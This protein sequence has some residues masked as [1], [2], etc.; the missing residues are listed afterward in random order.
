MEFLHTLWL[1]FYYGRE[2]ARRSRQN[3]NESTRLS[4]LNW[5]IIC[6]LDEFA[7][8]F[9]VLVVVISWLYWLGGAVVVHCLII[10]L[11]YF[12][13]YSLQPL[14]WISIQCPLY[15]WSIS[16]TLSFISN[17]KVLLFSTIYDD[18]CALNPFLRV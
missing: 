8:G 17:W 3:V 4:C 6:R 1:V 14:M 11:N 9:Q 16:L 13:T 7:W 18:W 10:F 2:M 5:S 12:W 15:Q